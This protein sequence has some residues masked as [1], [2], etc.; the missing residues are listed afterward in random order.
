MLKYQDLTS[1]ELMALPKDRTVALIPVSPLEVHGPH[2]T[3]GVDA[4]IAEAGSKLM[5]E[6]IAARMPGGWQGLLLPTIFAGSDTQTYP[7]TI[8]ISPRITRDLVH[9]IARQLARD[10]FQ[11][12]LVYNAHGGPR[13]MVGMEEVSDR[14]TLRYGH[15][16]TRMVCV[17][18]A[19]IPNVL[20]R[21]LIGK[22]VERMRTRGEP[23]TAADEK[24]LSTDYHS[25][26]VETSIALAYCGGSVR[27][28][29]KSAP[30]QIIENPMSI[31]RG[32]SLKVG[33]G[34]GHLGSPALARPA[35]GE[36][37][38]A[39]F[40]DETWPHLE[41]FLRRERGSRGHFHCMYYWLPIFWTRFPQY[42]ALLIAG[43]AIAAWLWR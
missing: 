18:A 29:Y 36:E 1:R 35:L 21:S 31:R 39:L 16:G 3:L 17:T 14:I 10:G 24:A 11:H 25:G 15:R 5:A 30:E 43:G 34:A 22:V 42:V 7:G 41:R 33:P 28:D 13:H 40:M 4:F 6:A 9:Q 32:S 38:M 12:I 19:L 20:P 8:E 23:L 37:L 27:P 26:M 2:A